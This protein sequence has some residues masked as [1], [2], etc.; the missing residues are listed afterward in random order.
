MASQVGLSPME[1]V[2]ALSCWSGSLV[3]NVLVDE[4]CTKMQLDSATCSF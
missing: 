3:S 2:I 4:M 1:L